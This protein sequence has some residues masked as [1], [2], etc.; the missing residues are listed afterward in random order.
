MRAVEPVQ[1]IAVEAGVADHSLPPMVDSGFIIN[2]AAITHTT[3]AAK[4]QNVPRIR[5]LLTTSSP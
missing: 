2:I 1:G 4:Y 5:L 3:A